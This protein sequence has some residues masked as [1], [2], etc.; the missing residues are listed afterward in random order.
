[1]QGRCHRASTSRLTGSFWVWAPT[2]RSASSCELSEPMAAAATSAVAKSAKATA[3]AAV[4]LPCRRVGGGAAPHSSVDPSAQAHSYYPAL[5]GKR[6][7]GNEASRRHAAHRRQRGAG[8][9]P[10]PCMARPAVMEK[11]RALCPP[12]LTRARRSQHGRRGVFLFFWKHIRDTGPERAQRG[13][14]PYPG[15]RCYC[16]CPSASDLRAQRTRSRSSM[17]PISFS[18]AGP[19]VSVAR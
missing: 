17:K 5:T 8:R 19:A 1:M 7:D 15:N 9:P 6:M 3:A 16:K 11:V 14:E 13:N 4:T 12:L 2:D 10:G 18:S